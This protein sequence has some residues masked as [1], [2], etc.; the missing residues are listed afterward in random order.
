RLSR[1]YSR[2]QSRPQGGLDASVRLAAAGL[3]PAVSPGKTDN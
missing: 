1:R 3:Y 2:I